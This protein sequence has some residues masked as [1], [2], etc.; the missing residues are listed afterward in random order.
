MFTRDEHQAVDE[1]CVRLAARF[2]DVLAETVQRTV[3]EVHTKFDGPVRNFVPILVER[4]AKARLAV[5]AA[6]NRTPASR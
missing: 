6:V 1:V 3:R 5:I 4:E 2:P